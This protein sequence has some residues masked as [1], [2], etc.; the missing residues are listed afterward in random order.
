M[1]FKIYFP[2]FTF[3][4]YQQIIRNSLPPSVEFLK[5]KLGQHIN[6]NY[7]LHIHIHILY[8]NL[9]SFYQTEIYIKL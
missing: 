1:F 7:E 4:K 6:I 2:L 3:D 5:G 8:L 9:A